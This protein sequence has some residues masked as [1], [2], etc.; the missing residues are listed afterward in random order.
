MIASATRSSPTHIAQGCFM[1]VTF[2][3]STL[4]AASSVAAP[5]S[6]DYAQGIEIMNYSNRPLVE[7]LL[8]DE[9]YQ[10]VTRTDLGDVRVFNAAGVAVPHA[11]CAAP[12]RE[13]PVITQ[14]SLPVFDLQAPAISPQTVLHK[15]HRGPARALDAEFVKQMDRDRH[16]DRRQ[17]RQHPGI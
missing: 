9:L 11:F 10:K 17:A 1:R 2:L 14:E 13:T 15:A 8:P 12:V 4:V 6:D 5:R 3:L 7:M 16:T